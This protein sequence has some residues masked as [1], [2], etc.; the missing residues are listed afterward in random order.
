MTATVAL[1]R[2]WA[3]EL[4][5]DGVRVN[6]LSPGPIDGP[7]LSKAGAPREQIEQMVPQLAPLKRLGTPDEAASVVA[8][9]CSPGASF[10]TGA[11]YTVG[12]AWKR[13]AGRAPCS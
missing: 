5:A 2:S 13:S 7:A 12:G 9:L 10:V 3:Q 1:A 11:N 4:E 8:F 6:A